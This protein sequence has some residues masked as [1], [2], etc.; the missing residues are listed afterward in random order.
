[1]AS[2]TQSVLK[3]S[4]LFL[5]KLECQVTDL[6]WQ[7]IHLNLFNAKKSKYENS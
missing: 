7:L 2:L 5:K 3:R 4:N 6:R 1:M